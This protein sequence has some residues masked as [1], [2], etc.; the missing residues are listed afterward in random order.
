[1]LVPKVWGGATETGPFSSYSITDLNLVKA[2][3]HTITVT[4][5]NSA[6][7]EILTEGTVYVQKK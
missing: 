2:L 4:L 1:M 6:M 3:N 7:S 5:I